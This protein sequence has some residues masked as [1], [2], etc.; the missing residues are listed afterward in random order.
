MHLFFNFAFN[1]ISTS[2]NVKC[3]TLR[4]ITHTPSVFGMKRNMPSHERAPL[5]MFC[6][7]HAREKKQVTLRDW[8]S[9]GQVGWQ[10]LVQSTSLSLMVH[11][12]RGSHQLAGLSFM[13]TCTVI[14]DMECFSNHLAYQSTD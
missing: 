12:D 9:L 7:A 14:L 11:W 2:H 6:Q 3:D 4:D 1:A 5:D 10:L 13:I 8:E